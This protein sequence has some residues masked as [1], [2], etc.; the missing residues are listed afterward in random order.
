MIDIPNLLSNEDDTAAEYETYKHESRTEISVDALDGALLEIKPYVDNP[1]IEAAAKLLQSLH[2]VRIENNRNVSSAHSF[3]VWYD[4]RTQAEPAFN[5]RLYAADDNSKDHFQRMIEGSYTN[6]EVNNLE[7]GYA[8][9]PISDHYVAASQLSLMRH[10]FVP[11]R[12]YNGGEGFEHGDPYSDVLREMLTIEDSITVLQVMF[13]PAP[14]DWY[15]NGPEGR[16]IDEVAKQIEQPEIGSLKNP[17][18]WFRYLHDGEIP[19][20]EPSPKDT[21]A[22]KIVQDQRGKQAFQVNIRILA[23]SPSPGEVRER[24]YGIGEIFSKFY[25]TP[26]E[27]GFQHHPIP[28]ERLPDIY[29]DMVR[30]RYNPNGAPMWLT[31]EQLAGVAH[32][33]N[34]PDL[35]DMPYKQVQTGEQ[36][37]AR[38]PEMEKT[39]AEPDS[40]EKPSGNEGGATSLSDATAKEVDDE[41]EDDPVS[42]LLEES[43]YD[44]DDAGESE[45]EDEEGLMFIDDDPDEKDL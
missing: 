41:G 31:N 21:E 18:T 22:A 16:S 1:G 34:D 8:F 27:Q 37:S 25:N 15:L 19:E 38:A 43:A 20:K 11:I 7:S 17:Q 28:P 6:T 42:T 36:V 5:L 35:P 14:G 4:P 3:E 24:A 26:T 32:I 33:P 39:R 30:R 9:P 44:T 23:A 40:T 2:G 45:N 10:P 13:K 12:H 29:E